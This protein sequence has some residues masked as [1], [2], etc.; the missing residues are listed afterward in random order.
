M[1]S[2]KGSVSFMWLPFIFGVSDPMTT[3]IEEIIFKDTMVLESKT[4]NKNP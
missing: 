2:S 4:Q 3:N 1:E